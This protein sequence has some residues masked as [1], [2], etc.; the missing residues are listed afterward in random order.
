MKF[1]LYTNFISPH[2]LPLIKVIVGCLGEKFVRYFYT[3]R[4]P[5]S[6]KMQGWVEESYDWIRHGR[7]GDG[8][9]L[10]LLSSLMLFAI[11][12]HF[13]YQGCPTQMFLLVYC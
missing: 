5:E 13:L 7:Y 2:Q 11:C 10:I 1:C 9:I 12:F 3:D 4:L 8:I 6:T